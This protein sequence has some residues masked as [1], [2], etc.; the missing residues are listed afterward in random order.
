MASL[1]EMLRIALGRSGVLAGLGLLAWTA[2]EYLRVRARRDPHARWLA[3]DL[4]AFDRTARRAFRWQHPA[5]A[6]IASD[7]LAFVVVPFACGWALSQPDEPVVTMIERDGLVVTESA[8]V[9]GLANQ[10][11]KHV[12]LRERPFAQGQPRRRLLADRYGSFFSGHSSSV[13]VISSATTIRR[14]RRGQW[15][16]KLWAL[17][18]LSL[19]VGY[20]RVAADKHYATDVICG[21]GVGAA[22]GALYALMPTN[23]HA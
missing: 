14:L 8:V 4:N 6:D 18:G 2:T 9:A 7:V 12:A 16:A 13:A 21:L 15:S 11:A 23:A 10:L 3:R 5:A 1:L 19:L 22:I 17:P 20:L